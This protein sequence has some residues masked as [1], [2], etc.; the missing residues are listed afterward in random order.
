MD[1]EGEKVR[2]V[3]VTLEFKYLVQFMVN[4]FI[5]P[6]DLR[7]LK[8]SHINVM[9]NSQV[10]KASDKK[11]LL[12]KHPAT[13]T[14]DKEVVTMPA[15]QGVYQSLLKLQKPNGVGE[16]GVN[17]IGDVGDAG[18]KEIAGDAGVGGGVA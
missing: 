17:G 2:G 7:V 5:R 12:L 11:F 10:K 9:T 16:A 6:S 13:K 15:A 18:V 4:S 3:Q 14:S 8:N 1:E